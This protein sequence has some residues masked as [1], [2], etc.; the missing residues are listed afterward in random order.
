MWGLYNNRGELDKSVWEVPSCYV[1]SEGE[2]GVR[3]ERRQEIK[4]LTRE[5]TPL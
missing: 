4:H 2:F 3:S 5:V 1:I